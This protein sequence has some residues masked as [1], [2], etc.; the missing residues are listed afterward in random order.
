MDLMDMVLSLLDPMVPHHMVHHHMV[1]QEHI[2]PLNILMPAIIRILVSL[3]LLG[4][5]MTTLDH[6]TREE[7]VVIQVVIRLPI[8]KTTA[9]VQGD[10]KE[11]TPEKMEVILQVCLQC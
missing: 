10:T 8:H 11:T 5:T 6:I 1:H 9:V 3:D 4:R 7:E 2:L